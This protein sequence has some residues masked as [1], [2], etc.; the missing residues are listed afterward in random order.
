VAHDIAITLVPPGREGLELQARL[1]EGGGIIERP[2]KW[3]VSDA[4]GG[5]VLD[6]ETPTADV[7]LPPGDYL[8]DIRY[9]AAHYARTVT[10]IAGNRLAVNFVLNVGGVRVLPQVR[11]IGLPEAPSHTR[12]YALSGLHQGQ[13]V[14]ESRSPGEVLR[15]PAGDYR[16]ESRFDSGNALAVADVQV[17]PGYLSA[18]QIDHVAGLARLAFVGAPDT[19]VAWNV[20]SPSGETMAH[21]TGLNA[22][23]VLKPGT[24]RAR[25]TAGSETLTATF[26]IGEGEARDI[27]L[28]N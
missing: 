16:I 4:G 25:A 21:L 14:A 20:E 19:D 23:V 11:G 13:I 6:S 26:A 24:Y 2:I 27:I 5:V 12:V 22:T 7:S 18:V 1:K 9:G 28:G 3:R 17:K 8:V 10:L 15:L